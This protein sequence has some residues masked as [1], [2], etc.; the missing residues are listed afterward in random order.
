MH[1]LD[2]PVWQALTTRQLSCARVQGLARC[3]NRELAPFAAIA[4]SGDEAFR[5]LAAV[6]GDGKPVVLI[7]TEPVERQ[8]AAW[9][10]SATLLIPQMIWSGGA[11]PKP[12]AAEMLTAAD[13]PAMAA[14]A[15]LTKPGPFRL[16]THELGEYFGIRRDGE[17]VAMAGERFKLPGFTEISA[18]CTHP[19]VAGQGLASGLIGR[20]IE[21]IV[22]RGEAPFLHVH[23]ENTNAIRLYVK[24]GFNERRR[25]HFQVLRAL[26]P[27]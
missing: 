19:A 18:V 21:R 13:A 9:D 6:A 3:F 24:L 1:P 14:L 22:A 23:P 10:C 27:D 8:Q 4:S 12:S 2:N 5:D 17:L 15:S 7:G 11:P 16:R 26:G 25:M 20:L